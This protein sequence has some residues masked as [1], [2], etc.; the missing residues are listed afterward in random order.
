[1]AKTKRKLYSPLKFQKIK[2]KKRKMM[3][4]FGLNIFVAILVFGFIVGNLVTLNTITVNGYKIKKIET[5][6]LELRDKNQELGL[7]LSDKQSI[8]SVMAKLGHLNMVESKNIRFIT[9]ASTAV[10]KR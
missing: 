9:P 1:M 5:Q 7:Q 8:E 6:L 4:I 10:A 2:R 3:P